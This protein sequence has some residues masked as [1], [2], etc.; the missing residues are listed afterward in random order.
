[1]KYFLFRVARLGIHL[2]RE[3]S[4][5]IA[6]IFTEAAACTFKGGGSGIYLPAGSYRVL[7]GFLLENL[8]PG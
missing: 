2:G 3:K 1:M 8:F 4:L 6:G 7:A 5:E